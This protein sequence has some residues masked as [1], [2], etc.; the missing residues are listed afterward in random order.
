MAQDIQR[1]HGHPVELVVRV[2]QRRP[3]AGPEDERLIAARRRA[4]NLQQGGRLVLIPAARGEVLGGAPQPA[5]GLG[6]FLGAL[7][8]D[9]PPPGRRLGGLQPGDAVAG[10][11]GGRHGHPQ[12][13]GQAELVGRRA[14]RVRPQRLHAEVVVVV[15][16]L[17]ASAGGDDRARVLQRA[18]P[19]RARVLCE[20]Q[21][22][23][24]GGESLERGHGRLICISV[25]L[26]LY[27]TRA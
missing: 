17:L 5:H 23:E 7:V 10:V 25:R 13:D 21:E 16:R 26:E 6:V 15:R 24:D 18:R 4:T 3:L 22:D 2:G 1:H 14:R 19:R 20:E 27:I 12:R 11:L 9:Q 8:Q